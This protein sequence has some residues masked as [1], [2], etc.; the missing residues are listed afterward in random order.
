M[1]NFRAFLV[2]VPLMLML[3]K[4]CMHPIPAITTH[5]INNRSN[6][7]IAIDVIDTINSCVGC[8]ASSH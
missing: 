3:P 7:L 8:V 5:C 2:A 1:K 4:L 6:T